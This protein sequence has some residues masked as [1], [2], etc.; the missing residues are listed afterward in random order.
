[1]AEESQQLQDAV[2][3]VSKMTED[4]M[5]DFIEQNKDKVDQD[6]LNKIAALIKSN[7][8]QQVQLDENGLPILS[9]D[10]KENFIQALGM[11][12]KI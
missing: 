7:M 11:E 2:N 12:F 8:P 4:E 1:M 5:R 6:K 10:Q 9:E 3:N